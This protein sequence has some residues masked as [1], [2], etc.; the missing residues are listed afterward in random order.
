MNSH[1]VVE[2]AICVEEFSTS[3]N[4]VLLGVK[5]IYFFLL[6]FFYRSFVLPEALGDERRAV[7]ARRVGSPVE[8][9]RPGADFWLASAWLS[10]P[11]FRHRESHVLTLV[12]T[13]FAL[14]GQI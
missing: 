14:L 7:H 13:A 11:L 3:L 1:K 10:R 8:G 9:A 6:D 5:L 12:A 4:S 2:K